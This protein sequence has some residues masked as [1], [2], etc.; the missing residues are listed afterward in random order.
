MTGECGREIQNPASACRGNR[1]GLIKASK[2]DG[3]Y[4][5]VTSSAGLVGSSAAIRPC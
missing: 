4:L 2:Q 3:Y 5:G 1:V